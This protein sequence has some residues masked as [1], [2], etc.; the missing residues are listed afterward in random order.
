MLLIRVKFSLYFVKKVK[1]YEK[2]KNKTIF[3]TTG[4]RPVELMRY[5]FFRRPSICP[6]NNIL[7]LYL[8]SN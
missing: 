1:L 6:V 5:P 8:L 4:R 7:L 3:S 2:S